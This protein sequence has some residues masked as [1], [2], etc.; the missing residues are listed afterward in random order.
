M[1]SALFPV[2]LGWVQVQ[3]IPLLVF[4][5]PFKEEISV[6]DSI[7]VNMWIFEYQVWFFT[8][9]PLFYW[10][11]FMTGASL[12]TNYR[13]CW[14]Y[15]FRH[16]EIYQETII[17]STILF[18]RTFH[19]NQRLALRK[20]L[21]PSCFSLYS[22]FFSFILHFVYCFY[23]CLLLTHNCLLLPLVNVFVLM[24][25]NGLPL[26]V[27]NPVTGDYNSQRWDHL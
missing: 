24:D 13:C 7:I 3:W 10:P 17:C 21:N 2:M 12:D 20:P 11:R 19:P 15:T 5:H 14:F 4:Y 1:A 18:W 9:I 23:N 26:Q 6:L 16:S 8:Y 25:P 27:I 22:S